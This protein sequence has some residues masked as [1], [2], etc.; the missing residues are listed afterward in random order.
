MPPED[1][2]PIGILLVTNQNK[3]LV[4]YATAGLDNRLFV[5]KYLTELPSKEKLEQFIQS[6][7]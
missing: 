6:H 3:T 7:L 5:Q 4:E 1:N 2:P